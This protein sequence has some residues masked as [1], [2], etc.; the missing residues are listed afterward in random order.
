VTPSARAQLRA[1]QVDSRLL[2][3]LA[4]LVASEPVQIKAF[5]DTGPGASPGLPLR[6]IEITTSSTRGPDM[7]AFFRAQRAPYLPA[8]AALTPAAGGGA[9]LTVEFAA[10]ASLGLL[11]SQS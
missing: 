3:T 4:A 5:S 6:A 8:Q 9:V 11:Q 2:I 10:P 7:L 1:G